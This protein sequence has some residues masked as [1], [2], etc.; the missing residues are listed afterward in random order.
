MRGSAA[1]LADQPGARGL[2]QG[3][4]AQ[5]AGQ[6]EVVRGA[7]PAA[8]AAAEA[9]RHQFFGAVAQAKQAHR[10]HLRAQAAVPRPRDPRASA[11]APSTRRAATA[12]GRGPGRRRWGRRP[13][14]LGRWPPGSS[15]AP[16][17]RA[18]P[19]NET[20]SRA[21]SRDSPVPTQAPHP[22]TYLA[23][24]RRGTP[25]QARGLRG[26][27]GGGAK[28]PGRLRRRCSATPKRLG[29]AT[30][31]AAHR[32]KVEPQGGR[33]HPGGLKVEGAQ[34]GVGA[35][36][37]REGDG[38]LVGCGE[39]RKGLGRR[40]MGLLPEGA[41]GRNQLRAVG[42]HLPPSSW[43]LPDRFPFTALPPQSNHLSSIPGGSLWESHS[44]AA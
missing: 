35:V 11:P 3:P 18:A 16:T 30:R 15:A 17:G 34:G 39:L 42:N 5:Q 26:W 38:L 8:R 22:L 24:G 36:E 12:G 28:G 25:G 32:D 4:S 31:Q 1:G 21:G 9:E 13:G 40:M 10:H 23:C 2:P 43:S 37:I 20:E 27:R 19:W 7:S 41:Q 14:R 33:R 6:A 44:P 29:L